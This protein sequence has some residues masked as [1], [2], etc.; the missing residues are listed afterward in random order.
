MAV[1]TRGGFGNTPE[2]GHKNPNFF[3]FYFMARA[4]MAIFIDQNTLDPIPQAHPPPM[5]GF[6][7]KSLVARINILSVM[8]SSFLQKALKLR[9]KEICCF[10]YFFYTLYQY[11]VNR[12]ML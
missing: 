1:C 10:F 8:P 3:F 12:A 6:V 7:T 2:T 5:L 9:N 4:Q 11:L